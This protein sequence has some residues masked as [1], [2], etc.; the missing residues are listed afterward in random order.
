MNFK[1]GINKVM[2]WVKKRPMLAAAI[3]FTTVVGV[4]YLTRPRGG[5]ST[6]QGATIPSGGVPYILP[7]QADSGA[8]L[9]AQAMEL[10]ASVARAQLDAAKTVELE[11]IAMEGKL[12]TLALSAQSGAADKQFALAEKA[13]DYQYS[14][15]TYA[16]MEIAELYASV[17][18][19]PTSRDITFW[20]GQ[21][22]GNSQ[23]GT[24]LQQELLKDQVVLSNVGVTKSE[25]D[26]ISAKYMA[27]YGKAPRQEDL[28]YW[29][30]YAGDMEAA[31]SYQLAADSRKLLT[32]A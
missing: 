23:A 9:Q 18:R 10:Q 5:G 13:L 31:L 21:Y 22:A 4:W 11:R 25:A 3:V 14:P 16:T 2:A 20:A 26:L 12:S 1:Q 6:S 27:T 29:G 15:N 8:G 17:G 7:N 19:E 24:T 30:N 32:G 28:V